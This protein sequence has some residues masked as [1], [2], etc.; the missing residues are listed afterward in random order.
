MLIDGR[1]AGF[2]AA[3]EGAGF[4]DTG[5]GD[6]AAVVQPLVGTLVH[7]DAGVPPRCATV[8]RPSVAALAE[9]G[10][11]GAKVQADGVR[12]ARVPLG[13]EIGALADHAAL[14][15]RLNAPV[16]AAVQRRTD[17]RQGHIAAIQFT[18]LKRGR[19]RGRENMS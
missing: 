6:A 13:A 4:V 2:A 19:E 17:L 1:P 10:V 16:G 18:I 3:G 5:R 12:V 8:H 15:V 11:V 14:A 7:V 9:T